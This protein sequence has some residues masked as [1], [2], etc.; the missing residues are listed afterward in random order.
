MT[1]VPASKKRLV[2]LAPVG[3]Q[4]S[5]FNRGRTDMD[6]FDV[7]RER[8]SVR[9]Y[10]PA[11][12]PRQKLDR[13]WE[14]VRWAPSACNLQP[15]RF[16]VIKSPL[17]RSRLSGILQDWALGAPLIVVALGSRVNAWQ[18]DSES[19]HPID[20][21]IATEHLVLA[22]AAEGLGTC[23]ICAFDRAAMAQALEL[24]AEW[25]PVAVTPLGYPDDPSPRTNR[26]P[27]SEI[28]QEL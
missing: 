8:R 15:W 10:R 5:R 3:L 28:V 19:I 26:K 4:E 18:R 9:H 23:W 21:A 11:P 24:P 16:L 25:D 12:V 7:V 27:L 2:H 20:V 17:Y 22:A 13:L 1:A 6:F 14:A